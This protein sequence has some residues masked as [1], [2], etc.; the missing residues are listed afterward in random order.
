MPKTVNVS[1]TAEQIDVLRGVL[2]EY[3]S[4]NEVFDNQEETVRLQLEDILADAENEL[5][6]GS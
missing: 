4:Q 5:Y 6:Q 2:F 1:L 3:Y